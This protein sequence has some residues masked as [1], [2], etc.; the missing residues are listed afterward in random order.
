MRE[1]NR[2]TRKPSN[3]QKKEQ[4]ALKRG[5]CGM[6]CGECHEHVRK[7]AVLGVIITDEM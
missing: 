5:V 4:N 3:T 6:R 2:K 1:K 7:R